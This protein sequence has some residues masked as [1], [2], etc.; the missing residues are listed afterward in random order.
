[1]WACLWVR[2][3]VRGYVYV[4]VHMCACVFVGTCLCA[5]GYVR[6]H[7]RECIA[8]VRVDS[9]GWAQQSVAAGLGLVNGTD[10]TECHSLCPHVC[11]FS[12][13][14]LQGML[15]RSFLGS[16]LLC[17]RPCWSSPSGVGSQL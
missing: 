9:C 13:H 6:V 5:R 12:L 2:V 8:W 1:M 7:V 3:R 11:F 17:R 16:C 10:N 15:G 14:W 4:C